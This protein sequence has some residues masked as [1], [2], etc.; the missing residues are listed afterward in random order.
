MVLIYS[1]GG[2]ENQIRLNRGTIVCV[3]VAVAIYANAWAYHRVGEI[4]REIAFQEELA[5]NLH[6]LTTATDAIAA[7]K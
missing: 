7:Q 1:V 5:R 4:R 6:A 3:L 2:K